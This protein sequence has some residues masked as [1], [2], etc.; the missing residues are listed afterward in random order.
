MKPMTD[1]RAGVIRYLK[2]KGVP[3]REIAREVRCDPKTVR[4]WGWHKTIL[5]SEQTHRHKSD[6]R[7]ALIRNRQ[8]IVKQL[9]EAKEKL[10]RRKYSKKRR[11][12]SV[13]ITVRKKFASLSAIRRALAVYHNI[14][15]SKTTVRRDLV[16]LGKVAR[17][18][19]KCPRLTAF[20]RAARVA[21]C[22]E[23]LS[24]RDVI[25][26]VIFSDESYLRTD[27]RGGWCWVDLWEEPDL[28]RC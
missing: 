28:C 27:Q 3:V 17:R 10:T 12:E 19:R 5:P 24:R 2:S 15:V 8:A 21:F 4:E 25:F 14:K 6:S 11:N 18:K 26:K 23:M 7:H 22:K 16:D 1:D 20:H 13:K 9:A